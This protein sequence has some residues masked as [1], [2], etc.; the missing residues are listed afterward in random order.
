MWNPSYILHATPENNLDKI[1]QDWFLYKEWYPTVT[2]SLAFAV[3]HANNQWKKE[4]PET[5]DQLR[6][7]LIMKSP[8]YKVI[9]A[10]YKWVID[11]DENKKEIHGNPRIWAWAEMES[12][13]YA[14]QDIIQMT[15]DYNLHK[16]SKTEIRQF[17]KEHHFD[18]EKK[19]FSGIL[20]VVSPTD[21]L[22]SLAW[23][24]R[25]R[26]WML[27]KIN[28]PVYAQQIKEEI[29]NNKENTIVDPSLLDDIVNNIL[30]TTLQQEVVNFVRNLFLMKKESDGYKIFKHDEQISILT[31]HKYSFHYI[32]E[33]R[34]K[35]NHM[36]DGT[37]DFDL[38]WQENLKNLN[39]FLRI[40]INKISE[41]TDID[42]FKD[43][44]L[45]N[46]YT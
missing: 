41:G 25:K 35:L 40:S 24:I 7:I 45:K 5:M 19:L 36:T 39:N 46:F 38:T 11:I 23:D 33:F 17:A 34:D 4:K 6:K 9:S 31:R 43:F 29:V 28:L 22:S 26:V 18:K 32:Q 37:Y 27:K 2:W 21:V 1:Q 8:N 44:D 30:E 15:L 10:W 42:I 12:W 13:I 20:A 16:L 14:S 3:N